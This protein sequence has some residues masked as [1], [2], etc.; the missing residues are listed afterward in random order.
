V[1]TE[2]SHFGPFQMKSRALK[3]IDTHNVEYD[4]FRR[5]Y[6]TSTSPIRKPYYWLE[7]HKQRRDELA[8]CGMQDALLT[9]SERDKEIFGRDV[10]GVPSF[11]VPNGTDSSYFTPSAQAPDPHALVFT[12]TMSWTPNHDGIVWFV[13][14]VLPKIAARVPDVRLYVVGKDPPP[15]VLS[16][17]SERVMVTGTVM[18]VR[19]YVHQSSVYVVP[20]RMGGGTRVKIAEAMAMKKPIVTTAIGC[21]GIDVVHERSALLADDPQAFADAV[22]RLLQ[23]RALREKLTENGYALMKEKY[24]WSVIGQRVE[25][26]FRALG[27]A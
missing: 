11:V 26:M 20:L 9:T 7:Y 2:F 16:R 12:G 8:W 3:I 14:E 21:E 15:W 22:V 24:E 19:P 17:A 1:V 6:E 25:E 18:D 5:M 27:K 13:D 10:P 23:D 4:I